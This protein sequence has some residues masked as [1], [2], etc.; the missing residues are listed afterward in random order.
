MPASIALALPMS[1]ASHMYGAFHGHY[2]ESLG[3]LDQAGTSMA[4]VI[5]S[6]ALSQ[7]RCYAIVCAGLA[8]I[9]IVLML[10]GPEVMQRSEH[11]RSVCLGFLV[12]YYLNAMIWFRRRRDR[13]LLPAVACIMTGFVTYYFNIFGDCLSHPFFHVMLTPYMFFLTRSEV[14]FRSQSFSAK[15]LLID[16]YAST[17]CGSGTEEGTDASDAFNIEEK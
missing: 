10:V 6:W 3:K 11:A 7:S 5:V 17:S 16:A 1:F 13:N 2:S 4:C 9:F 14:E 8:L 15:E 12:L